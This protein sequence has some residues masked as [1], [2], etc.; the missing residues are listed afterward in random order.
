MSFFNTTEQLYQWEFVTIY[1]RHFPPDQLDSRR[2]QSNNRGWRP[3]IWLSH[4]SIR[5][6]LFYIKIALGPVAKS[7]V[8]LLPSQ[9]WN[10]VLV[11][12]GI[13]FVNTPLLYIA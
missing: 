10:I 4:T 7:K 9:T 12:S 2:Y 1:Y 3:E 11:S 8:M 5:L 6:K 13:D